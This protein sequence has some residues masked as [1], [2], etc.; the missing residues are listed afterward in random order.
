MRGV[1]FRNRRYARGILGPVIRG[2]IRS[3]NPLEE[4]ITLTRRP[5]AANQ[6]RRGTGTQDPCVVVEGGDDCGMC[7]DS[8]RWL[9][10][11]QAVGD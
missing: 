8:L 10:S 4:G 6:Q 2:L 11:V 9:A 5:H 7:D 3:R 1:V